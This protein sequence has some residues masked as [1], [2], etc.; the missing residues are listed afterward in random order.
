MDSGQWTMSRLQWTVESEQLTMDSKKFTLTLITLVTSPIT[1]HCSAL[2]SGSLHLFVQPNPW[3]KAV[4]KFTPGKVKTYWTDS[5]AEDH[6]A[7]L[8]GSFM[9][10]LCPFFAHSVPILWPF[11]DHS[12]AILLIQMVGGTNRRITPRLLKISRWVIC[13][14]AR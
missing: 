8:T 4:S 7:K 6:P 12:V 1:I 10:I 13:L 3:S 9:S 11:C 14:S 5:E 2:R